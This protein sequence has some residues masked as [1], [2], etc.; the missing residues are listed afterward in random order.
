MNVH[1]KFKIADFIF[2]GVIAGT[3]RKYA[4]NEYT[5]LSYL[6][7]PMAYLSFLDT[8]THYLHILH[9]HTYN[10]KQQ[11]RNVIDKMKVSLVS[12][13]GITPF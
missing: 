8:G 1:T 4:K 7:P 12:V 11:N 2:A 6:H 3:L 13:I 9:A 5:H 10:Y